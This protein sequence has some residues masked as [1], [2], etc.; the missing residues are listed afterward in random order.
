MVRTPPRWRRG[1]VVLVLALG[2]AVGSW[3]CE[4][5]PSEVYIDMTT[6]A[7]MGDRDGFLAG[8][9]TSSRALVEAL[10]GLSEAYGLR[11]ANPYELLVFD[12]IDEEVVEDQRAVL[13][14]RTRG[15]TRKVL[16]VKEDDEWRI[17]TA[18]LEDF[19]A[20]EGRR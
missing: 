11:E 3:G 4:R 13:H 10:I 7:Q 1:S 16:M 2:A 18:A 8:F 19:W 14:V 5:T 17:D 20:K 9:T 6:A 15:K 12:A